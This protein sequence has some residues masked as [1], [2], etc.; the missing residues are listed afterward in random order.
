M[1]TL[2]SKTVVA[3]KC[4]FDEKIASLQLQ[5]EEHKDDLDDFNLKPVSSANELEELDKNLGDKSYAKQVVSYSY[6]LKKTIFHYFVCFFFTDNL[7]EERYRKYSR[8]L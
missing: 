8:W 1:E 6:V 3:I 4:D 7:H 5:P 2:I